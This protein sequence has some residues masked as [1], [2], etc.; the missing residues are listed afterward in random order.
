MADEKPGFFKDGL[1]IDESRISALI[2]TYVISFIIAMVLCIIQKDVESIKAI[3]FA[4]IS[5]VTGINIT[6][7]ITSYSSV[8]P[9]T[10]ISSQPIIYPTQTTTPVNTVN[11]VNQNTNQ[12]KYTDW[13][14]E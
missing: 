13:P 8:K 5:A 2:I 3:V 1:S 7:S 12:S 10:I 4:N 11:T 9:K 6:N 14:K